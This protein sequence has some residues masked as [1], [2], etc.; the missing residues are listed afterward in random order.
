MLMINLIKEII[1]LLSFKATECHQILIS[2]TTTNKTNRIF[3][4]FFHSK[5]VLKKEPLYIQPQVDTTVPNKLNNSPI[6]RIQ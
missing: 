4:F 6:H 5:Q 2:I 3:F 1:I